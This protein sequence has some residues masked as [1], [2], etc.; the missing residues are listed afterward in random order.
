[1][2]RREILTWDYR[3]QPDLK[4]LARLVTEMSGGRV[5]LVEVEDTGTQDYALIVSD[6][7][8]DEAETSAVYRRWWESGEE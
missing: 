1:M 2:S 8:L 4:R 6:R 5:H 3:E 7:A